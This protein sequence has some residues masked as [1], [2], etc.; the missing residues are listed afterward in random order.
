MSQHTLFH[1]QGNRIVTGLACTKCSLASSPCLVTNCLRGRG[2]T[3]KPTYMFVTLAPSEEEDQQASSHVGRAAGNLNRLLY[4]SLID[5][6][7]CYFTHCL[8]CSLLRGEPKETYWKGCQE[9]FLREVREVQPTVI[10]AVGSKTIS[11]LTGQTGMDKVRRKLLPLSLDPHF[12]VYPLRN[13]GAIHHQDGPDRQQMEHSICSDL[14]YLVEQVRLGQIHRQRDE[15]VD[16]QIAHT[17]EDVDRF[18]AELEAYDDI[19]FDFE[20]AV[21]QGI[22]L[23][24]S[25]DFPTKD[26]VLV[27]TG[28]S[29]AP[30]VSRA[31]PVFARGQA[32]LWWWDDDYLTTNLLPRLADFFRRKFVYGWNAVQ[33]DQKIARFCLGVER[34]QIRY[35]GMLNHYVLNEEQGTHRLEANALLYTNM[36]PWKSEFCMEDTLRL[37]GYL[38]CDT[39]SVCRLRGVFEPQLTPHQRWL[40]DE[41]ILPL[42]QELFEVEWEGIRVDEQNFDD[43]RDYLLRRMDEEQQLLQQTPEVSKFQM[44]RNETFNPEA[45]DHVRVIMRDILQL[46][47]I[48]K[49]KGGEYGTDKSVLEHYKDIP[50]VAS[51]RKYRQLSKLKGTYHDQLR[52]KIVHHHDQPYVSDLVRLPTPPP[53]VF[54][55]PPGPR[56]HTSY[57]VHGTVTGRPA[58]EDPNL[59]N[60]PREDTAGQVLED[61][62]MIKKSF[63][64]TT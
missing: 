4:Q 49:T 19:A 33:F 36:R 50:F 48:K 31:I 20:V 63:V 8:R 58:S 64:A 11:W 42:A 29:P 6:T 61:A 47:S 32:S 25:K 39:D 40:F 51:V 16:Y 22:N 13:P 5:V 1:L 62:N 53:A 45:H 35:D 17:P 37:C 60:L 41:L 23:I 34:L 24:P 21:R 15:N 27:A 10:V 2:K 28:F 59:M 38:N 43:L 12:M 7:D 56:V 46:P 18:L 14:Q 52:S 55:I 57:K 26:T 44:M 9:H 30:G 3:D 54:R